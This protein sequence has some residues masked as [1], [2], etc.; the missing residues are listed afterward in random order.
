MRPVFIGGCDRSGTTLLG[1]MLGSHSE[2]LCVPESQ[3][4]ID[5]LR[6]LKHDQAEVDLFSTFNMIRN[7]WRF[8]LWELDI[9]LSPTV[10]KRLRGSYPRLIEW[11]IKDYGNKA[12]KP[13]SS[14]WVDHTPSNL[15]YAATLASLFPQARFIH[16]VRDGR[17]VAS[18]VMRL[19]WG[20]N[21]I[22]KAAHWWIENVAYG[23]AAE[24]FLGK[25]KVI[26]LRYEDLVR[27][28]T[29]ILERVCSFLDIDYQSKMAKATGFKVPRFTSAQ[30]ALVG[31]PPDPSRVDAREKK[32]SPREVEIFK[33]LT[34]DSLLSWGYKLKYGIKARGS[35]RRESNL[36]SLGALEAAIS[37]QNF[38]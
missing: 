12:G 34:G 31:N 8:K 3:F 18:S 30:H 38:Y 36:S 17:A 15:K 20:P 2:C 4:K 19:D 1:A 11:I 7:H 22:I 14:I 24:S 5:V 35:T 16:I 33:S 29:P 32:L 25:G 28:P 26:R 23:L 27:E 9:D 21:T 37:E 10:E 13:S 6:F